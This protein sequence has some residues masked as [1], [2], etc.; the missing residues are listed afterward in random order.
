MSDCVCVDTG[1]V[2]T[3]HSGHG[4]VC[5]VTGPVHTTLNDHDIMCTG[6]SV[7]V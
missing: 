6:V 5:M 7:S 4:I 2:P 3:G 1:H